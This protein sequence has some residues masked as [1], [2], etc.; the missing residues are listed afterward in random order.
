MGVSQSAGFADTGR[1]GRRSRR[2]RPVIGAIEL[3]ITTG[4]IVAAARS[5]PVEAGNA[6]G[7]AQSHRRSEG[8]RRRDADS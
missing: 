3:P 8:L 7:E 6:R 2:R 1:R 4:I 5:S